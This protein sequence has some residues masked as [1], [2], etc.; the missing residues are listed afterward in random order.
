[1]FLTLWEG[2]YP[3]KEAPCCVYVLLWIDVI[4]LLRLN[5][6]SA[7]RHL[8]VQPIYVYVMFVLLTE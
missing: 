1:M 4:Y 7:K 8:A 5:S 6:A 3:L 2:R